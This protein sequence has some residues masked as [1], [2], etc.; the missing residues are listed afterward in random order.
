[1]DEVIAK[2]GPS[3]SWLVTGHNQCYGAVE[4]SGSFL[5]LLVLLS[6]GG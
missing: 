2:S 1:M 6:F 4:I 3:K 5:L